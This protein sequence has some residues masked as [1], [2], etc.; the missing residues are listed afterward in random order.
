MDLLVTIIVIIIIRITV[1]LIF[2]L[3]DAVCIIFSTSPNDLEVKRSLVLLPNSAD[4]L[5]GSH[6]VN[7]HD[8]KDSIVYSII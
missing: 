1:K 4:Q 3:M 5:I 2:E 7:S 6:L 8:V